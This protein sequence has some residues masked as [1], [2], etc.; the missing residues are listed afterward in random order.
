[1]EKETQIKDY[2]AILMIGTAL[3][4]DVLQALIGWVPVVGNILAGILS[5]FIFC[6]FFLWFYMN[7]I[8][9]ITPKRLISMV[10]GGLVEM[11][12]Y[13]N[14]LPA[15]TMVVIFLIGTTKIKELAAKHSTLARGA[16]AVEG[17]IKSMNKT[18]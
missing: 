17:K 7:G 14:L 8:R 10:G 15:W 16:L 4:F 1:M 12:P 3:F 5:I 18:G 13:L 11:V 9:M 2:V 6:T